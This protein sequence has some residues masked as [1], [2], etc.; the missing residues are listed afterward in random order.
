MLWESLAANNALEP[1][2]L[3]YVCVNDP[4]NN[5]T[6]KWCDD[7]IKALIEFVLFHSSGKKW[8]SPKQ[9]VFWN[10]AGQFV[11]ERSGISFCRSG[12]LLYINLCV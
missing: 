5:I 4:V 1:R 9:A 8:P 10:S 3:T 2:C 6:E 12:M 11:K 7:E